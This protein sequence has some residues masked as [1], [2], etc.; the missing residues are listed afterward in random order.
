M[1]A[2]LVLTNTTATFATAQPDTK[3][4]ELVVTMT[5]PAM[6]IVVDEKTGVPEAVVATQPE[7]KVPCKLVVELMVAE[8]EAT[9]ANKAIA[10][11]TRRDMLLCDW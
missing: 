2:E 11:K 4:T 3:P 7:T 10:T 9:K 8:Q 6:T 1:E 5:L